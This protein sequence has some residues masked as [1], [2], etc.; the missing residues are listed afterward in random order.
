MTVDHVAAALVARIGPMTAMKLEKLV[1]YCQAWHLARHGTPLF[2]DDIQAWREGP[3]VPALYEKHRKQYIVSGWK[4]GDPAAVQGSAAEVIEWVAARYGT[5]SA[6][7]LSRM[8][9]YELPWRIAR[10]GYPSGASARETTPH[11]I[12]RAY[13]VRQCAE[14]D[15]AVELAAA[16]SALEGVELDADWQSRL[17]DV[18]AGLISADELVAAEIERAVRGRSLLLPGNVLSPQ[19]TPPDRSRP[20]AGC[21]GTVRAPSEP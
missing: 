1:Y 18:A 15:T 13:Y 6:E 10:R 12:I 14:P 8:T 3:V 19:Q 20:A 11:D 5:F 4:W 16:S 2:A 9:H 17:R 21:R 7:R